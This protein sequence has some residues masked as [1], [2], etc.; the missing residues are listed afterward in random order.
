MDRAALDD[1][2]HAH[3]CVA[4]F[5]ALRVGVLRWL[6]ILSLFLWYQAAAPILPATVDWIL[7]L[8]AA[9]LAALAATYAALECR[10][11]GR[12]RR[13]RVPRL[14]FS[15]GVSF[16]DDLRAGLL[17]GWG[18]LALAPCAAALGAPLPAGMLAALSPLALTLVAARIVLE[19][20]RNPSPLR[21]GH[22]FRLRARS[23]RLGVR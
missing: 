5:R 16:R 12:A 10:W 14:A 3:V 19:I 9:L 11:G 4:Y 17:S 20:F 6:A 18:L 21:P 8:A 13:V 1:A 22:A 15:A 23:G 2:V 7:G